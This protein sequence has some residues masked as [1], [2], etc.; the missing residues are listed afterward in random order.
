M[1]NTHIIIAGYMV[2][3]SVYGRTV[4]G[5]LSVGMA[6]NAFNIVNGKCLLHRYIAGCMVA[7]CVY[8]SKWYTNR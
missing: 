4:S 8:R 5:R 1:V 2:A 3:V 7:E 6:K